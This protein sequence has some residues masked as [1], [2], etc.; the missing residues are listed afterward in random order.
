MAWYST[1]GVSPYELGSRLLLEI[2]MLES[3]R[4]HLKSVLE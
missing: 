3:I 4:P 1:G 2:G